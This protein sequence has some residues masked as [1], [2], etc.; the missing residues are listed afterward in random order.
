[1]IL[2]DLSK[3]DISRPRMAGSIILT[4]KCDQLVHEKSQLTKWTS[5]SEDGILKGHL[6]KP[7]GLDQ[8]NS[9]QYGINGSVRLI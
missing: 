5:Y 6:D 4:S 3:P 2:Q 9:S 7:F 1:M 8:L